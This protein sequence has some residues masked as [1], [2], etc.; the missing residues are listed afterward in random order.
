MH[1]VKCK[2][3]GNVLWWEIDTPEGKMGKLNE[4]N[5]LRLE[6]C[7]KPKIKYTHSSLII[8]NNES[9]YFAVTQI[10]ITQ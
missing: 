6:N 9:L 5:I 7:K 4:G 3:L 1:F 8:K 2:I 10:Y